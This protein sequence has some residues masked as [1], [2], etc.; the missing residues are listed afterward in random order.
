MT[1]ALKN[2]SPIG[3]SSKGVTG[4][5]TAT[6]NGAPSVYS[7]ITADAHGTVTAADYFLDLI[8]VLSVGDVIFIVTGA[9]SGGTPVVTI[10]YVVSNNGT[11]I[12]VSDG[13]TVDGTDTY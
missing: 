10:A 12:D 3:N 6:I 2:F 11:V 7:Y 1:F 8:N 4:V 9:G 5:G 13:N